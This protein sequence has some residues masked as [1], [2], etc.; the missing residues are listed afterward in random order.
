MGVHKLFFIVIVSQRKKVRLV[1]HQYHL[2]NL[3][4]QQRNDKKNTLA[5]YKVIIRIHIVTYMCNYNGI[6]LE[7]KLIIN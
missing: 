4:L 5:S 1:G 7:R 3:I 2:N 6:Q